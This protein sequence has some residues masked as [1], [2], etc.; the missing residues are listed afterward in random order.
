MRL[1][2]ASALVLLLAGCGGGVVNPELMTASP[3]P[4]PATSPSSQERL[5]ARAVRLLE[6]AGATGMAEAEPVHG[7][8]AIS[9]YGEWRGHEVLVG[10]VPTEKAAFDEEVLRSYQVRDRAVRVVDSPPHVAHQVNIARNLWSLVVPDDEALT[11]ELI[12]ALVSTQLPPEETPAQLVKHADNLYGVRV[13]RVG[14]KLTSTSVWGISCDHYGCD[15]SVL[16]RG[17]GDDRTYEVGA[18]E[19]LRKAL[20]TNAPQPDNPFGAGRLAQPVVSLRPGVEALIGGSDGATLLPFELVSRNGGAPQR[21]TE[22]RGTQTA[23]AVVLA[24]GRLVALLT[25]EPGRYALWVSDGDDWT[26]Y[27]PYDVGPGRLTSLGASAVPDPVVWLQ[28]WDY[29]VFV[30]TDDAATFSALPIR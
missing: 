22:P 28:T 25:S 11:Q 9:L 24:D 7:S 23:G 14:D 18:W 13:E 5:F 16:V 12:E 20:R 15:P 10:V 1:L 30:S 21:I 8:P 19:D 17:S 26:T 29:D 4:L 27:V 6:E 3:T 2:V